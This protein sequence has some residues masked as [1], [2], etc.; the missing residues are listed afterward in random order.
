MDENYNITMQTPMRV[1]KGIA[2]FVV[3]VEIS[4][5]DDTNKC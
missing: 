3:M 5:K 4:F 2:T 1:E